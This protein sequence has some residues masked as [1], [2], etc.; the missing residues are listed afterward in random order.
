MNLAL[1]LNP[2]EARKRADSPRARTPINPSAVLLR[3]RTLIN[4]SAVLYEQ[5]AA[6]PGLPAK[7]SNIDLNF[8]PSVA[9]I[10]N[11][12][13]AD[14]LRARTPI[15]L[16]AVLYE[17][18]AAR[19][20]LPAEVSNIDLNFVPSVAFIPNVHM[21]NSLRARTPINPSAVLYEQ[22]AAQT[23]LPAKVS[24]ISPRARTLINPS[25]V[26]YEQADAQSGL[27]AE[28][29]IMDLD[30]VPSI[31][32]DAIGNVE[33]TGDLLGNA[34][35]VN[36][37]NNNIAPT[38]Q[39]SPT[40]LLNLRSLAS[41]RPA[42]SSSNLNCGRTNPTIAGQISLV[43]QLYN[44]D[45]DLGDDDNV[46]LVRDNIEEL[47]CVGKVKH[48]YVQAHTVPYP[49]SKKYLGN[50][51]QQG[52]IKVSFRRARNNRNNL[53][54]IVTNPTG[55]EF[56]RLYCKQKWAYDISKFYKG[57]NIQL[58]RPVFELQ[59][60]DYYNPQDSDSLTRIQAIDPS[61]QTNYIYVL[62]SVNKIRANVADVFDTVISKSDEVPTREP[63]SHIK[64]ELYPHQKQA[65]YFMLR[66]NSH[67]FYRLVITGEDTHYKQTIKKA[68]IMSPERASLILFIT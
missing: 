64:T 52:R 23:S 7:V 61:F 8:V 35:R 29:S 13:I 46:Q 50:S 37:N 45:A 51:G 33:L 24:N 67:K 40:A 44:S 27:P 56:S 2:Q 48:T 15:N 4:L 53:N 38:L 17:Q 3:A 34:D 21:A 28:V 25:A 65:L 36:N 60:Y 54:I 20:S 47:I 41:K 10:P 66:D 19:T 63:S 11:V 30:F 5:S 18:A 31:A 42:L 59:R 16:S 6:R 58:L 57:K 9:F 68:Y 12:H 1:L 39:F 49:D 14:S 55:R 26:L 43:E 22:A 62:R 32:F